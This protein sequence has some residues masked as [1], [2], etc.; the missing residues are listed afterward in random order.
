MAD[1]GTKVPYN[2]IA[3]IDV[4]KV[5]AS[6]VTKLPV[7]RSAYREVASRGRAALTRALEAAKEIEEK[8]DRIRNV[9]DEKRLSIVYQGICNVGTRRPVG[10]ECLARFSAAP[11]R[12]PD[13]W[14]SE[15]AEVGAGTLLELTAIR[16]AL[17][18]FAS[19]PAEI[20]L[21]VNASP[22]T[23]LSSDLRGAL[24]GL[25]S[26]RIVLELTEHAHFENYDRLVRVLEPLRRSGVRLAVDDAGAGYSSL[27][28][29][30][31]LRPDLIKLD[32]GLTRNIDLDP[33]RR[34]LASALLG[35]ARETGSRIIAEGVELA[36]ELATLRAL[37]V[38][39][40]QGYFLGPPMPLDSL[41]E[42]FDQRVG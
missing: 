18:A 14:F 36:S 17:S 22:D 31:N 26:E 37:G 24:D 19:L 11:S 32:M 34:A 21:A 38:E 28:H 3:A 13:L 15:A 25:P 4:A 20:F 8:L 23:I 2:Q 6:R 39:L 7:G 42:L 35:F 12:T 29:I 10:F 27:Q 9:I 16:L 5:E 30:L 40:A 33:A 41:A 1:L